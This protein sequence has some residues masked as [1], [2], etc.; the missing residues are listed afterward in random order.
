MSYNYATVFF[1]NVDLERMVL[2]YC[3]AGIPAPV[4]LRS[5]NEVQKLGQNSP[6]VG[7]FDEA[8]YDEQMVRLERDDMLVMFT[9]G[10][11]EAFNESDA[12]AGYDDL[13]SLISRLK[14]DSVAE[15]INRVYEYVL[16]TCGEDNPDDMT[17]LGM[18]IK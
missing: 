18:K 8:T 10:A 5:K 12:S 11:Y 16:Q 4:V 14:A 1:A 9:D 7:I 2:T 3:N 15:A 17:I 13:V 6:F